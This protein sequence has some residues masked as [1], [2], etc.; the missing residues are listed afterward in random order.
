LVVGIMTRE[1]CA[2]RSQLASD[3]APPAARI[4]KRGI[5]RLAAAAQV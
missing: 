3:E 1:V 4:A 2:G 5:A